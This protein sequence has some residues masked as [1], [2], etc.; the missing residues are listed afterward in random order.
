MNKVYIKGRY[1]KFSRELPQ[2]VWHCKK[3]YGKGCK[4]CGGLGRVYFNSVEEIIAKPFLEKL[5]P[6]KIVFHCSSREDLNVRMLG[7]GRPFFLQIVNPSKPVTTHTLS[8]LEREVNSGPDSDKVKINSLA[9]SDKKEMLEEFSQKRDKTYKAL[10]ECA[11]TLTKEE[12]EKLS[13]LKGKIIQYT[14]ERVSHRRALK[15]RERA[16]KEVAFK[17][18]S[19]KSFE[20]EL[21]TES[22][23]YIKELISGH[24]TNPS[25]S[26]L[27]GKECSCIQLDVIE[28]H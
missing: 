19:K 7:K 21:K 12:L 3:C 8:E 14:P 13:Q 6:Q 25:V 5:S 22:G 15:E 27:L 24:R 28:I 20:L 10:I 23:T 1:N 4:E 18:L 17:L 26:S 2:T 16:V 11:Q 9:L